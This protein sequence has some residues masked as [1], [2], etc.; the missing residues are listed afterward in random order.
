[1]D[2]QGPQLVQH[3]MSWWDAFCL[4]Y[5]LGLG[6]ILSQAMVLGVG[7]ILVAVVVAIGR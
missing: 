2:Q 5:G 1:M 3:R 6:L 7:A 4:G